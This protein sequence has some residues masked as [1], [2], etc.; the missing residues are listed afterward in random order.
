MQFSFAL[1]ASAALAVAN[2]VIITNGPASFVGIQAGKALNI[3]WANAEGPVTLTLKNGEGNDLKNVQVIAS[4]QTGTS[5]AW[6]I[7]ATLPVDF[8]AIQI[9]DGTATPNF[10]VM[11]EITGGP[12]ASS[13]GSASASA[14]GSVTSTGSSSSASATA[15]SNSTI[16][17]TGSSSSRTGSA[18]SSGSASRT[19]STTSGTSTASAP[20]NSNSSASANFASPLAF[21][22]L[23]FAA[24]ITLN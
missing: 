22:F 10:S 1:I 11:F 6:S 4:G 3:S 23:A 5:Y 20:P 17:S 21:V 18:T 16:T 8:Y 14:S 24:L 7:P 13:S 12:V 2:A 9:N 19:A 15:A